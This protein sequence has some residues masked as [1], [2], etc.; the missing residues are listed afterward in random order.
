[1]NHRIRSREGGALWIGVR[2]FV[3]LVLY[4]LFA[5]TA[6]AS[7]HSSRTPNS[8]ERLDS[9]ES[10]PSPTF[11][12]Q[13][14]PT[15]TPR[16]KS[17]VS[18][19]PYLTFLPFLLLATESHII[20]IPQGAFLMGCDWA[21]DGCGGSYYNGYLMETPLHPVYLNAYAIDRHEVTN[22]EYASC[23][24]AGVCYA[25]A[26][27]GSGLI[28]NYY[29]NPLYNN[30]PVL[31]VNWYMARTYCM[32]LGE[33]LPTEAEWEKAARGSSDTRPY[34]W[35]N[36]YPD[37]TM[38][39]VRFLGSTCVGD[40]TQ[41]GAYTVDVSPYGVLEMSGNVWNW[42]NDWYQ[43]DYYSSSPNSNPQ[44][45][46][47]PMNSTGNNCND[48]KVVRGGSW[49]S[50]RTYARISYRGRVSPWAQANTLGIRCA[51][52]L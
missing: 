1:M 50:E 46:S 22:V 26:D 20:S 14:S 24:A 21:V 15:I 44:G 27:F 12:R 13:F 30:Y 4:S 16:S 33:R 34:P 2:F 10:T 47:G 3:I 25:P 7:D 35:G 49:Y 43:E 11:Q 32:W 31:H 40:T 48:C 41:V 18:D 45:P 19:G 39:N 17:S 37:C 23:V 28:P 38:A 6:G 8:I 51:R 29:G 36:L 52:S 42:V 5:L 9:T